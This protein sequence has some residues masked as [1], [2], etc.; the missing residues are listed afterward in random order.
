MEMKQ[1]ENTSSGG[2][3]VKVGPRALGSPSLVHSASEKRLLS[4]CCLEAALSWLTT[5]S[6]L[7]CRPVFH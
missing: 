4:W 6:R 1:G 3:L 5:L 2:A 7:I